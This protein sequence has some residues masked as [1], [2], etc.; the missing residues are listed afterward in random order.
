MVTV[1]APRLVRVILD[2][3][4]YIAPA[5]IRNAAGETPE[6]SVA[7]G[8][9]ISIHGAS[10]SDNYEV[11]PASPL[12]QT[13]GNVT[14]RLRDRLLA[15]LFVSPGQINAQLPSDLEEG[16]HTLGVRWGTHPE[17]TASFTLSRNAPGLFSRI[18]DDRAFAIALHEDGSPVTLD[19]PARRGEPIQLLG[20]GFGP[21]DRPVP[22]GFAVPVEPAYRLLDAV[23]VLAGDLRIEPSWTGAAAG[24]VGVSLVRLRIP[25]GLATGSVPLRLIIN[26]RSSN[27]VL[28]PVA[29]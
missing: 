8:S 24:H 9:L 1:G 20:T 2:R 10:L 18:V 14:V 28:L 6:A 3:S 11:G 16:E 15:L 26:Q 19:S 13:L 22:D 21:Y 27:T 12:A 23:D 25:D 29:E 7:A 17:V 4:P 5:G